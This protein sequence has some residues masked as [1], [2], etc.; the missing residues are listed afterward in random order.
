[1]KSESTEIV[2]R[3]NKNLSHLFKLAKKI[4]PEN[5]DLA[6]Y[7]NKFVIAKQ[8]Q[9][10]TVLERNIDAFWDNKDLIIAKDMSYFFNLDNFVYVDE[11]EKEVYQRNMAC[12]ERIIE[13]ISD[14]DLF[15][16]WNYLNNMLESVIEYKLINK[17]YNDI[18]VAKKEGKIKMKELKKEGK[19]KMKELK[20]EG[21]LKMKELKKE[22]KL[23]MDELKK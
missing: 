13:R 21:K 14:T 18:K 8:F 6:F 20:K 19:L 2:D 23:K 3:F 15:C 1:M 22:G 12:G 7:K 4:D 9:P 10:A 17:E 16:I 5:G 11:K